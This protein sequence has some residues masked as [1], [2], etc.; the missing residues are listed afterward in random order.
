MDLAPGKRDIIIPSMISRILP[1]MGEASMTHSCF[2]TPLSVQSP[3]KAI[4]AVITTV[5]H[6]RV[7]KKMDQSAH[8]SRAV[9]VG[10]SID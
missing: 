9:F 8:R 5:E 2:M 3:K 4:S 1:F 7:V 6:G 10:E